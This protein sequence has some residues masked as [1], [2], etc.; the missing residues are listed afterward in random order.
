MLPGSM[1]RELGR[2]ELPGGG[3]SEG[4]DHTLARGGKVIG[5]ESTEVG[6]D[7]PTRDRGICSVDQVF[8]EL[9]R[10][11]A[12][13]VRELARGGSLSGVYAY[14]DGALATFQA[15]KAAGLKTVY[16]LPIGHWRAA[17]R[18]FAEEAER[19]PEWAATLVGR[20]R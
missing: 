3:A 11:T 16:D 2:A 4:A 6:L 8:H 13:H 12:R 15:A 20:G 5:C 7:D 10:V 18:I 14:E 19:V 17:Q 1:A 9:D